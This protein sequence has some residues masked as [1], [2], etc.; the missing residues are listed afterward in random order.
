MSD[1]QELTIDNNKLVCI[2]GESTMGK[3]S[4]LM[5]LKDPEG[6]MY[7]NLEGKPLPFKSKF[8]EYE[9]SDPYQ[10]Y[11][12][13]REAEEDPDIHTIIVDSITFAMDMYE[14]LHVVTS[15]DTR[16]A[17][18][19][20]AQFFKNFMYKYVGPCTKNVII[21]AHVLNEV[22]ERFG[23]MGAKIPVKGSLKNNGIEAYFTTIVSCKVLSLKDLKPF[24]SKLLNITEDDEMLGFKHVY[25]TRKTKK[26][27]AER[28][29][30]PL[31]MWG[32]NETYIDSNAQ[33]VL[34]RLHEYYADE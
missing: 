5:G 16:A 24:E 17:W 23:V 30:S 20:Y 1:E 32:T 9:L 25:Q 18:G 26:T 14:T 13:F 29:R 6:V 27:I 21:L 15:N 10:L 31:K 19:N 4:S 34:D 22:D 28:M 12:G 8:N 33:L 2:V 7:L 11:E 3:S